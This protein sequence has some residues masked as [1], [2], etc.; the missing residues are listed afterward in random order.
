MCFCRVTI[1]RGDAISLEHEEVVKRSLL[2]VDQGY[3]EIVLTG[4]NISAYKSDALNLAS[5]LTLLL[6]K[7][8][9]MFVS[10]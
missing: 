3:K 5:L 10:V 9:K 7:Y 8:L 4:V 6:E 1:A 2:L